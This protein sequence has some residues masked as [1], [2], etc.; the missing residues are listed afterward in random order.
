MKIKFEIAQILFFGNFKTPK[1]YPRD[2]VRIEN[3]IIV[4]PTYGNQER[5][6]DPRI[7]ISRK[8]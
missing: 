4:S 6:L 3:S 5:I 1:K 8:I 2:I 7:C